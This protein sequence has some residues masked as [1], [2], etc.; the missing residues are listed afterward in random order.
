MDT[1]ANANCASCGRRLL[2]SLTGG[3]CTN[4]AC[5]N[6]PYV[7]PSPDEQAADV[8]PNEATALRFRRRGYAYHTIGGYLGVSAYTA[9]R[10]AHAA[11]RKL[12][13]TFPP[14]RLIL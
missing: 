6:G 2:H 3:I 5:P 8:A 10:L 11:K 12:E 4:T 13:A 1:N 9:S 7:P 14:L